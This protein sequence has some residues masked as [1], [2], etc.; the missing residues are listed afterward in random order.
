MGLKEINEILEEAKGLVCE[1]RGKIGYKSR[2]FY[3][4]K[5]ERSIEAAVQQLK[6]LAKKGAAGEDVAEQE[7]S[8]FR[9]LL[10]IMDGNPFHFLMSVL[11]VLGAGGK[12]KRKVMKDLGVFE[13]YG[14]Y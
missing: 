8:V 12:N 3:D 4:D 6:A 9:G 7:E 11:N 13:K 1:G 14:K 10:R 5:T 2:A